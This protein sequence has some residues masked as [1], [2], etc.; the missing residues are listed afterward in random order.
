MAG[1]ALGQVITMM[2]IG[3]E[4]VAPFASPDFVPGVIGN[5]VREQI[6]FTC[7]GSSEGDAGVNLLCKEENWVF[8]SAQSSRL[9]AQSPPSHLPATLPPERGLLSPGPELP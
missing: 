6:W 4:T 9:H 2:G 3:S 1:R 7:P 5:A 8:S